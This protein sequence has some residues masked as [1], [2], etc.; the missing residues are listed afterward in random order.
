MRP[1]PATALFFAA[2]TTTAGVLMLNHRAGAGDPDIDLSTIGATQDMS[3][4][5]KYSKSAYNITPLTQ[6][7]I[8][9]R[10][11]KLTDEQRR[12]ILK[13]GTEPAFCGTL[14]DNKKEGVYCCALCDLPLFSSN[15]KFDSGTGWPSFFQPFDKDHVAY[16]RDTAHG[17]TRVEILCARCAGHLGH[18]FD[19]GPNPT[20][21]RY[22][23]NSESLVFFENA[24][25]RPAG[26]MPIA[27]ETAYFAGGC[28]WGVEDRLQAV[29][30]VI[31]AVSGYQGGQVENPTY[32]QVCY[33]DTGHAESVR[34]IFDPQ[35]VSYR[36]LLEVFF[37]IHDPT[38]LNR[39]GPDVGSQYRSAIY[40]VDDEQARIAREYTKELQKSD[41]FKNRL[42]VTH[43]EPAPTF[44]EAE[45]YHQDYHLKHGGSCQIPTGH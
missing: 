43:I 45:E 41:R 37:K 40:T 5:P 36:D 29:P 4:A 27:T 21:L 7:E 42:I 11:E 15:A 8:Q 28:F 26:A 13:K 16:E 22:C 1:I 33:T 19:D 12:V 17:M 34:V 18:V 32:K 2:L 24:E 10:A 30:G 6:D 25:D 31:D 20:G 38:T 35:R 23:L 44:Y 3:D 14:L 39:Q 9:K